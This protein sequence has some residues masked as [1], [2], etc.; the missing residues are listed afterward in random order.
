SATFERVADRARA[1]RA[2]VPHTQLLLLPELHLSA[3]PAL[4]D[5]HGGY[6]DRVATQV[7]GPITEELGAIARE[8]GLWLVP[9]SLYER[10]EDGRIHNTAVVRS[11]EGALIARYRKVF[12]WQR[13]VEWAEGEALVSFG[14]L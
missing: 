14:S 13:Q 4:L 6:P 9:G 11:A 12:L 1:V 7:P 5:E 2:A 10:A 8:T 3:P